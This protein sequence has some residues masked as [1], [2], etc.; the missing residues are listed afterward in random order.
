MQADW[1]HIDIDGG[2][3]PRRRPSGA[4]PHAEGY[5]GFDACAGEATL[6]VVYAFPRRD[7]SVRI[8][9]HVSLLQQ[10]IGAYEGL[11]L[12]LVAHVGSV[13]RR[14]LLGHVRSPPSG[15]AALVYARAG[16]FLRQFPDEHL[17][18]YGD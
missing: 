11:R 1:Q 2:R 10:Q 18:F 12:R 17:V 16:F 6:E 3:E 13:L 9:H 4:V 8:R 5:L 14:D 15:S 7:H